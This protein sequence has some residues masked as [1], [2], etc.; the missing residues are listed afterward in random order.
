MGRLLLTFFG[1]ISHL[2]L[3]MRDMCF[4][5]REIDILIDE[6]RAV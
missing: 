3:R 4:G 1:F 6:V 2:F 5:V